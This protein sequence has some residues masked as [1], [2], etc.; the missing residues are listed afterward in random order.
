MGQSFFEIYNILSKEN[1]NLP[2]IDMIRNTPPYAKFLTELNICKRK[3]E[4]HEKV[5]VSETISAVRQRDLPPKLKDPGSFS[6]NIIVR[7]RS[8]H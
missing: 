5:M 8:K 3:Y 2:L 1:V 4:P 6:V 7:F